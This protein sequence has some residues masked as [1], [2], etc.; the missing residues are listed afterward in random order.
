MSIIEKAV[1]RMVHRQPQPSDQLYSK[2][3]KEAGEVAEAAADPAPIL[4]NDHGSSIAAVADSVQ[5]QLAVA[6]AIG[7]LGAEKD[8]LLSPE[9]G[10][11]RTAEEFRMIK[12]P[13]LINAFERPPEGSSF[14]NLLMVTSSLQSEGKT[15]TSLN[16]AISITLEMDSTVLLIDGDVAKPG[17][18]RQLGISDRAGL[19][20]R[21]VDENIDL[22]KLLL[23]T[24]IPKLTIL[25]AGQP[26]KRSTELLASGNMRRLLTEVASRY[27]DRIVI[28]D[29]PPV[30][31][32][33][34]A[35]VL[36]SLMGQVVLVVAHEATPQAVV[37]EAVSQFERTDNLYLVLNK[38]EGGPFTSRYGYGYGYGYGSYGY[39]YGAYGEP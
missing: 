16:L 12:R 37:R 18:S 38:C 34:E 14:P 21:L 26:H 17:L 23:K 13:L 15:F 24:D 5:S 11:S 1:D 2:S 7:I 10:R 30:L 19:I 39:G 4:S 29:S 9:G 20:E 3:L 31:E 28:F 27:N 6:G 35:G 36:G 25:P 33:T 8:F 22:S 32:T